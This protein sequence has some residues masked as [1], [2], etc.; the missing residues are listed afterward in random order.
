[1]KSMVLGHCESSGHL[2][3]LLLSN[4]RCVKVSL[5]WLTAAKNV[6]A[7]VVLY[8]TK[9]SY[10]LNTLDVNRETKSEITVT[11]FWFT[12]YTENVTN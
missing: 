10:D 4:R 7:V 1:M 5:R 8:L 6:M 11:L 3:L 9:I 2:M 12:L